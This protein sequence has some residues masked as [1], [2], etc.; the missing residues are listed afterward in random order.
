[1]PLNPCPKVPAFEKLHHQVGGAVFQRADV[2][3]AGD[4]L[5]LNL[6]RRA[7]FASKPDG[8]FPVSPTRAYR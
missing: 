2:E 3:H 1:L 8:A 6:D 7:R 5:A 4:V